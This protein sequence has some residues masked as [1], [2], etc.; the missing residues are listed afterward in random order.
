MSRAPRDSDVVGT[1]DRKPFAVIDIGSNSV[2]MVVYESL[3]RAALPVFNEK[4]LCGL[5][6]GVAERGRLDPAA[7]DLAL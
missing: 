6:R 5:G 3:K 1:A 7:S 2:R 4:V